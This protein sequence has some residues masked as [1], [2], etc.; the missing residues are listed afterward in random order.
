MGIMASQNAKNITA[1]TGALFAVVALAWLLFDRF[2]KA[3][4]EGSYQLGQTSP[5]DYLLFRFR[6]VHNTGAAWG[7]FDNSTFALGIVSCVVCAL[8]LVLFALWDRVAGHRITLFETAALALV[9]A[10][11]LGNA[12]DRFSQGFVT[13]FIDFTFMSFPVFNIADIGVTCG[14]ALLIIAYLFA[15]SAKEHTED[16]DD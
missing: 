3:F 10:G 5:S 14:F 4:F 11:G 16:S 8:I 6:L 15:T 12:F 7:M 13:D 9:F 1:K 2:T